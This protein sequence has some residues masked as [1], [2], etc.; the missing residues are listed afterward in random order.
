MGRES[1]GWDGT[2]L[3]I[4]GA[5]DYQ[6]TVTARTEVNPHYLRL[7]MRGWPLLAE[8]GQ[9]P[10]MWI[11]LW[12]FN[13]KRMHQR[14]YTVVAPDPEAGTFDLE[15]A[16]HDGA[17]ANWARAA[18]PGDTIT[19]TVMGSKFAVPD[20][21]PAGYLIVGDTASLPA[22]NS[23]LAAIGDVPARVWL[24]WQH[25]TDPRL[26]VHA[27]PGTEVTWIRREDAG[28]ALVSQLAQS[29]FDAT[30]YY[31]WVACDMRTTRAVARLLR[32]Q[33]HVDRKAIRSTA[34]WVA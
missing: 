19:A 32:E 5:P 6:L 4:M 18:Q 31:A 24:E 22:V 12:F 25:D 2:V 20:P 7:R 16:M 27:T 26:P 14:A 13:G 34:Y 3:R 10:T 1:R 11:R 28:R 30:G 17:A 21:A 8:H 29:A 23:L 15:F 9:H 33:F